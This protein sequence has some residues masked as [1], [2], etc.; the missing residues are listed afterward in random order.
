MC[1]MVFKDWEARLAFLKGQKDREE[2]V[3]DDLKLWA[4]AEEPEWER[5]K[6]GSIRAMMKVL[7]TKVE[8][9]RLYREYGRGFVSVD[10]VDVAWWVEEEG[11][12]KINLGAIDGLGLGVSGEEV[13]ASWDEEV[14]SKRWH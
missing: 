9:D 4:N 3:V 8:K 13:K 11:R 2:V 1:G 5:K 7:I 12:F 14:R 10:D 6:S